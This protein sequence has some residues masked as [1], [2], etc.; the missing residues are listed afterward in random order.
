MVPAEIVAQYVEIVAK[1]LDS[2]GGRRR[3]GGQS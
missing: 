1:T 3:L 2:G